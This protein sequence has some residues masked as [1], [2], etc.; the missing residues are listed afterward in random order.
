MLFQRL[1][2]SALGVALLVGSLQSAVQQWQAVPIIL[3]AERFEA[4]KMQ[5]EES[6]APQAAQGHSHAATDAH[7]PGP[8]A[9]PEWTPKDGLERSF[10]TWVANVMY[11]SSMALLV[12]AVMGVSLWRGSALSSRSLALWVAAAGWLS[13]HLW[14]ALGLPA[15]IPGM[16]VEQLG[17]RQGWW[18][19]AALSAALACA[20]L[21]W[22]RSPLRWLAPILWLAVPFVVGAPQMATE[23]LVGFGPEA[24]SV[25]R[26]LW[27]DFVWV[28]HGLAVLFWASLGLLCGSVFQR[29]LRPVLMSAM[30]ADTSSG[31]TM[32]EN[33]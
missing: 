11:A 16:D 4:Q 8:D 29:W 17:S 19:L 23:S 32:K 15:E 9:I 12:L 6:V 2:W 3:A 21:A 22:L 1:I 24:K 20:S 13:L 5:P 30:S 26:Q 7:E 14:P 33:K 18:A 10:W 31:N 25:L 28:S 27:Q